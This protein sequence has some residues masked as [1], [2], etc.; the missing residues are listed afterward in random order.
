[1]GTGIRSTNRRL[2]L[3]L[4]FPFYGYK[5]HLT[6]KLSVQ[7]FPYNYCYKLFSFQGYAKRNRNMH[8]LYR[9]WWV[10]CISFGNAPTVK[11]N[12]YALVNV[13]ANC[14]L[15]MQYEN[16]PNIILGLTDP[17]DPD[18]IIYQVILILKYFYIHVDVWV[19][20]SV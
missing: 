10:Y 12:W 1:M 20:N 9:N 16:T 3:Y 8:F 11:T 4:F 6:S 13:L 18:K 19:R 17:L 7:T 15:N 5:K 14:S 2:E